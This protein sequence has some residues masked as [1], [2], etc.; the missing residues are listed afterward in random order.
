MA[1]STT[2][3]GIKTSFANAPQAADNGYSWTEDL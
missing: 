2:S 1:S 3:N